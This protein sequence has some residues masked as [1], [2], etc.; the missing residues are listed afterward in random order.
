MRYL[1]YS[2]TDD[3]PN[4]IVDGTPNQATALCLS[5]WR[6]SG[7]PQQLKADLSAEVVF[8]Y[9]AL[10]QSSRRELLGRDKVEVASNNHFDEDGLVG[11]F[12]LLNEEEA[13]PLREMLVDIANC[14]D[15]GKYKN[16]DAARVTFVIKAWQDPK[17]SPL[18]ESIFSL[19]YLEQTAIL[20]EELIP[21]ISAIIRKIDNFEPFWSKPDQLLD[22][23]EA[24]LENGGMTIVEYPLI[25]LAV[26]NADGIDGV[27]K[28]LEW[29]KLIHPSAIHNATEMLR[30]LLIAHGRYQFYYRY[31]SW[32]EL[33][34]RKAEPRIDLTCLAEELTEGEARAGA[35]G[36][37]QFQDIDSFS[38]RLHL[39]GQ[40]KSS[41][42]AS[43]FL[44]KLTQYL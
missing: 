38:P 39:V 44:E 20:Y 43:D 15:F 36:R 24:A 12:A 8:N 40:N 37:W 28:S 22:Q 3:Y 13:L 32:V 27:E 30:I 11:L 18:K 19:P 21:R 7:T 4:I 25:D 16:R 10:D 26:V 42:S 2:E 41:Y 29:S 23:S 33:F 35:A 9:L 17:L 14:G 6:N 1:S 5:H 31:E 34:T